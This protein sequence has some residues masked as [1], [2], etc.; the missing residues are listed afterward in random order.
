VDE[1]IYSIITNVANLTLGAGGGAAG[2]QTF[3]VTNLS[4]SSVFCVSSLLL[5]TNGG[6]FLMT[7]GN[8]NANSLIIDNG[9]VFNMAASSL[10][11]DVTVASGGVLNA[12]NFNYMFG[13]MTVASGGVLNPSP[14]FLYGPATNSGTINLTTGPGLSIINNGTTNAQGSLVNQ[15]GGL[16]NFLGDNSGIAGGEG[17]DYFVN[18]G[19]IIKSAGSGLSVIDVEFATNSGTITAQTGQMVLAGQWTLLPSGS[20]NVGLNSATNYGNFYFSVYSVNIP[21]NAGLAGA[22]NATLNN[23]YVPTNG[24]PFNV[25]SY[26]SFTGNFSSLGL[27]A[28]VMWQSTYGST[29]FTLMAKSGKPQFGTFNLSGTNLTFSGLGGSPG[30]NYV[31]LAS[32]NL[33]LPL[34]NWTALTTNTFDGTGH[35]NYTNKVIPGKPQQ[36][37]IFKL[38]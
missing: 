7:N 10:Y 19:R 31:I 16:I 33:T 12:T 1:N 23:G 21:G 15:P 32:T 27:P 24:T 28:G 29:N 37:F 8:M 17:H 9:G 38:P 35:F 18:Q 26:G 20:L 13:A 34:I 30:S 22:F 3:V 5:V 6:V 2:V 14:L 36:F 25:V 4:P 11:G